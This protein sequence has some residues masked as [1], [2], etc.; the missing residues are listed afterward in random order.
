MKNLYLLLLLAS[1]SIQVW[2][3]AAKQG[4][5]TYNET[6]KIT[7][8]LPPEMQAMMDSLPKE[9]TTSKVLYFTETATLY[10]NLPKE[11]DDQRINHE[12]EGDPLSG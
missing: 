11:S 12:S 7:M 8:S 5:I 2:A 3:Q 9:R 1:T 10:K 4:Q 6:V